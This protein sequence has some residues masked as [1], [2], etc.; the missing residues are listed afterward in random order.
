MKTVE[1]V[2]KVTATASENHLGAVGGHG[3]KVTGTCDGANTIAAAG[4]YAARDV[5]SNDATASQGDHWVFTNVARVTGG[6][7]FISGACIQFSAQSMVART[8]LWLFNAVP[9][10]S[11]LDDNAAFSLDAD[12]QAKLATPYP[13]EFDALVDDGEIVQGQNTD[14]IPFQCAA[15]RNL[16]GILEFIDA[17]TNEAASMTCAPILFVNPQD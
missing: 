15:D 12:D 11:E 9:S 7:G 10:A 1:V 5:I 4:N 2:G 13:I 14:K 17:E 8:R 3:T 16:Y 6:S